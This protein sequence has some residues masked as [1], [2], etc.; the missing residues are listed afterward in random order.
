MAM[1]LAMRAVAGPFFAVEGAVVEDVPMAAWGTAC[2]DV[3]GLELPACLG[4]RI[5]RV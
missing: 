3:G 2:G 1:R 5:W 4:D